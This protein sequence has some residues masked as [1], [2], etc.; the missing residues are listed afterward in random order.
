MV[1]AAGVEPTGPLFLDEHLPDSSRHAVRSVPAGF[2][3]LLAVWQRRG[4]EYTHQ[5]RRPRR[6]YPGPVCRGRVP[7]DRIR[8]GIDAQRRERDESTA[9][10]TARGVA[11]ADREPGRAMT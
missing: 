8:V 9:S 7:V 11:T 6:R 10:R 5:T 1:E 2:A 3:P 4:S